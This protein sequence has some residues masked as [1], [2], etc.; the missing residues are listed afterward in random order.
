MS[1]EDW[2][3]ETHPFTG[4]PVFSPGYKGCELCGQGPGAL[5]HNLSYDMAKEAKR[6]KEVG[7]GWRCADCGAVT[8]FKSDERRVT[9]CADCGHHGFFANDPMRVIRQV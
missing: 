7:W 2:K 6:A 5:Q 8:L 4:V 1:Q 3:K 9:E